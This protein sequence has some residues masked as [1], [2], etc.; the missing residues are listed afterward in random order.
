MVTE[1]SNS[2]QKSFWLGDSF[3]KV[4][5]ETFCLESKE[6]EKLQKVAIESGFYKLSGSYW[7]PTPHSSTEPE[8]QGSYF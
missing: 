6:S 1:A 3:F 5:T 4:Y 8:Q 2:L 7:N